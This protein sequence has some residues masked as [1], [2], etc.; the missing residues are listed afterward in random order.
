MGLAPKTEDDEW[1]DGPNVARMS[2]KL[3]MNPL[4]Y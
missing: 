1:A 4:A 3:C 2:R